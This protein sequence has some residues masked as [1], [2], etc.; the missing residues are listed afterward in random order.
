V[1]GPFPARE[2]YQAR[3]RRTWSIIEKQRPDGSYVLM[4]DLAA[5]VKDLADCGGACCAVQCT[6]PYHCE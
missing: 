1:A 6:D 2:E 3:L 5:R 4:K